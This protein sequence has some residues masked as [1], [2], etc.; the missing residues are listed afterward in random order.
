MRFA[1]TGWLTAFLLVTL[2]LV[3]GG[4]VEFDVA[5]IKESKGLENGGTM[6]LMPGGGITAHLPARSF[7]TI[8]YKLQPY[9]LVGAPDWTRTIYWDVVAKPAAASAREETFTMLQALLAQRFKLAFHRETRR[10]DGFSLVRMKPDSL[11]PNLRASGL[12]CEANFAASPRCRQGG[13]TL[14]T[15]KINGAPIWSLVQLLITQAGGPVDDNT[16]LSGTFDIELQW[17]NETAPTG[18]LQSIFTAVQEQL[19]LKL[20]RRKNTVEVVVVDHIERPEPD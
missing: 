15:F 3:L 1:R 6:R 17:S 14:T 11:G 13:I 7:I 4:Q 18:D 12:D 10:I 19:G 8:G 9:Q 2:P 20:E 16:R 5:S